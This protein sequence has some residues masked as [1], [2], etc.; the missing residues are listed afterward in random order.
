[1]NSNINQQAPPQNSSD[2]LYQPSDSM[3]YQQRSSPNIPQYQAAAPPPP[4]FS[5]PQSSLPINVDSAQKF[6]TQLIAGLNQIFQEFIQVHGEEN[7]ITKRLS[8]LEEVKQ[9]TK[10]LII[11]NQEK[12]NN[13]LLMEDY[14]SV[15]RNL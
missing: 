8:Q 3:S 15:T 11:E 2:F 10:K 7:D 9:T 5:L 12:Q 1:M 13:A 6:H 14:N 4:T